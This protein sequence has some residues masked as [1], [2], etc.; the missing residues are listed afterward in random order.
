MKAY[1]YGIFTRRL[2]YSVRMDKL[3][4]WA[5]YASAAGAALACSLIGVAMEPRFDI[6]NIAMVYLLAVVVIALRCSRGAAIF[7]AAISMAAFDFMFVPPAGT[8]TVHDAQYLLTFAIMLVVALVISELMARSQ[9]ENAARTELAVE[10]ETEKIRSA[11]LASISHDLRTPLAV[12]AGASSSLAQGGERIS[13]E[14]RAALAQS[15][16]GHARDISEQV[17]KVLQMTRFEMGPITLTRDWTAI[18]EIVGSVLARLA[19]RLSA[20]KLLLDIPPDLPLVHVDATLIDQVL[21]NLLENAARHTPPGT[22][23]RVRA[24]VQA[25]DLVVS[26]EDFGLGLDDRDIE[27]VFDKFYR[28]EKEGSV[29]GVGLGLAICRAIVTLHQGRIWAEQMPGGGTV[30]RFAL[31]LQQAPLAPAES[32]AP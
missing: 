6:V 17:D 27:R 18:S 15:I 23:V 9:R 4:N 12:I 32:G 5:G 10:A 29:T 7:S 28:R 19:E 1:F 30:F 21:S 8:F 31:P 20:H 14:E 11:L 22:V 13:S 24:Q 3:R 16:Y 26:V 25:K 2:R